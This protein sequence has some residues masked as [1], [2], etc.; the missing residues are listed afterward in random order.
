MC[1]IVGYWSNDPDFGGEL[2]RALAAIHHRGPDDEGMWYG[3]SVALGHRR[4]SILDLSTAG[5]QPML[6]KDG[7]FVMVFNGEVYNYRA[8][9]KELEALGHQ[10]HGSGDSEVILA[11]LAQWG[12]E[13]AVRRFI[14]MFAIALWDKQEK[15]LSLI[16][17]RLGVKP[18]YYGWDGKNICFSSE[19]KALR[20]LAGFKPEID[21]TA[22]GEYFQFGYI[23]APRSIYRN[24]FKVMPGCWVRFDQHGNK[25]EHQYWSVLDA[26]ATPLAGS[27]NELA[28]QLESLLDDAFSLRMV[29]D[30]PVG[31][32]LS[33]GVDSSVLAALLQKD[34]QNPIHTFT[35]G[36]NEAHVDESIHAKRV[37]E[38]LG[39]RHTELI[40]GTDQAKHILPNWAKLYDEPFADSSGI[41]TYLVSRMAGEQV[42][43]VLSA[44]GGDELFSGY[45]SYDSTMYGWERRNRF[46][47][48]VRGIA[49]G[50][51]TRLP[52]ETIDTILDFSPLSL[53]MRKAVKDKTTW[54]AKRIMDWVCTDKPGVYYERSMA[55]WQPG[56]ISSLL[57]SYS[58]PRE[59][60]DS[61]PGE[62]AEQLCLWDLHNYLPGDILAKVDR[63][64]MAASIEGREPL[65][66]HRVV[67]FA[68]RLPLSMR[69]G[70]LGGKHLLKK[71]LYK[72]VPRELVDR[73]KQ[74]FGIPLASWLQGD[75]SYM[76]DEYLNRERIRSE[77]LLDDVAVHR[78][79][80]GFKR[81]HDKLANKVWSLLAFQMWH[82]TWGA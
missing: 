78:I 40:L 5:H 41:P 14:G 77:G 20:E 38:Y 33:G 66:D 49:G 79:V 6:S 67:E 69:R 52:L 70:S 71:V 42:K 65:I 23:N 44:D 72:H 80:R 54:K 32:F 82:E 36:F 22:L 73:P 35:I 39:T 29:S 19:L 63:A 21:R 59:R 4:L 48:L 68:F 60:S 9:R 18:L 75:M 34:R 64:T 28:D 7:R 1:G 47:A 62:L 45:N 25:D 61:Y 16:R 37:S 12:V 8:V 58:P 31:V 53:Q 74:G 17:D 24:V 26:L 57:G 51:L 27:E 46:P 11:A 56:E 13:S 3:N 2:N 81:G 50:V 43:V 15:S 30:V 76:L 55:Y 10:F